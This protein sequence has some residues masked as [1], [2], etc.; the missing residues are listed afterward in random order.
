MTISVVILAA[1]KGTRMK[2][3]RTKVLHKLA[4]KPL[5][6]HVVDTAG[7]LVP[8]TISVIYGHDGESVQS[9]IVGDG[10][11]WIEQKEQKGTGHAVAQALPNL[12]VNEKVLILYGDVPLISKSS[13]DQLVEI[14]PKEG[15]SLLTVQLQDPSGYGRIIRDKAGQI[16][17][18][19]EQKDASTEQLLIDEVNT[20]IMCVRGSLLHEWLPKLENNNAQGEFYLTDIIALAAKG[21]YPV[22]A[23]HPGNTSEVEGVNDRKQLARLERAYQL[24]IAE[25][26][27]ENGVTLR[28][29]SR[30]D[31]RGEV[32]IGTDVEIDINVILEGNVSIASGAVIGSNCVLKNCSIGENVIIKENTVVDNST[33][34]RDCVIG[35]FARIRPH[36]MLAE[37]VKIGNFV[38]TKKS[39]IGKGSKV[40]H[41][42]Y[43]GDA[44]I[45]ENAN[46]GAGTITCNY[47]GVNKFKT[48]IGDGAF[49]GSNTCL[50]A[51]VKVGNNA[52]TGA[53][54][55]ISKDI[56]D[57]QLSIARGKQRNIE[58]WKRPEKI[59]QD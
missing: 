12:N 54:S 47:D 32:I 46:V 39:S 2:S 11:C 13:L 27:M 9:E 44:E 29:P 38:E 59:K 50:I 3:S 40:S 34:D 30:F 10:L 43:I 41:L 14:C 31:V 4:G 18:I 22:L 8:R 1:G 33:I 37:G 5:L 28:D 7:L 42:S 45:G 49:I 48:E 58:G 55:A 15:V 57:N 23:C 16:V 6:Q 21:N 56:A 53:G 35:P 19:A 25:T 52:T 17:G 36:T 20:G 26:L 51:P 24:N